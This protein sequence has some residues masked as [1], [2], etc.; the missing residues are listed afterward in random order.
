MSHPLSEIITRRLDENEN[1]DPHARTTITNAE[2]VEIRAELNRMHAE[3]Q[4]PEIP[5][6]GYI[7]QHRIDD[8]SQVFVFCVKDASVFRA[9]DLVR[10]GYSCEVMLVSAIV[11]SSNMIVVCRGYGATKRTELKDG[12][13][14]KIIGN[15]STENRFG[16]GASQ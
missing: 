10:P 9:D 1:K 11:K 8:P 13:K 15:I 14:L 3:Q 12:M 6:V 16:S 5:N 7:D 4:V 2:A